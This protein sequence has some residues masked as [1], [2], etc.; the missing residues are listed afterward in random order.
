VLGHAFSRLKIALLGVD[1]RAATLDAEAIF[2]SHAL[3]GNTVPATRISKR[4]LQLAGSWVV[5]E[6]RF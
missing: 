1:N 2:F 4:S 3:S 5:E 6:D